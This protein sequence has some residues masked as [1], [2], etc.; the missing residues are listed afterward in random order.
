MNK[1]F[2]YM[3]NNVINTLFMFCTYIYF[4]CLFFTIHYHDYNRKQLKIVT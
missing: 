4:F 2:I 1:D 3:L